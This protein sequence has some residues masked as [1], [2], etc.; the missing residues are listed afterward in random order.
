MVDAYT[1]IV[2]SIIA[3]AL[4]IVAATVARRQ[5]PAEVLLCDGSRCLRL[6]HR[7]DHHFIPS[8][9]FQPDISAK[10]P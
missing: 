8:I 4:V 9:M 7:G 2:L 5:W 6:E 10:Q 3:A 1:K